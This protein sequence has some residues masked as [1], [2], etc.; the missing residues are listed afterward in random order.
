MH[1]ARQ[2]YPYKYGYEAS[3]QLVHWVLEPVQFPQ[4]KVHNWQVLSEDL[5]YYPGRHVDL[6][7]VLVSKSKNIPVMHVLHWLELGPEQV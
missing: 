1:W 3:L 6:H 7:M 4:G 2:L 5:P